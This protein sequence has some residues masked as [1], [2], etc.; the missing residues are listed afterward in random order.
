VE[1]TTIVMRLLENGPVSVDGAF[2]K[3]SNL[4]LSPPMAKGLLPGVFVSGS[5][6]AGLEAARA[7]GATAIKYPKP[8]HEEERPAQAVMSL[9]VRVGIIARERS[10]H[11]WAIA[12][13]RF[14]E[15]R[16]GQLT[17]E[18]AMKVSD[19][20]WHRELSE[21]GSGA[22]EESPYWLVPFQNYKT[23]CPYL[24]GS[25]DVVAREVGRYIALGYRTFILDVPQDPEDLEHI[26]ATFTRAQLPIAV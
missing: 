11:A 9:G 7:M 4:K 10:D 14:P 12:R 3:T 5:S 17:H 21:M 25:Y 13:S 19:S 8:A 20:F 2:Y 1:Y 24:V 6:E 23:M 15:D 16:R 22:A 26:R 18:L